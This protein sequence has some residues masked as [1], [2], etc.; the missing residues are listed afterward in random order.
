[1]FAFMV[2]PARARAWQARLRGGETIRLRGEVDAGREPSAYLI[3][4]AIILGRRRDQEVVFSCHLDHPNPG[5]NDN[6]SGCAG[7]LEVA[8]TL[9][10]LIRSGALP[11]PERTI[12]FLWPAEMEGTIS[13]LNAR[14][15]SARR[16]LATIHPHMIAGNTQITK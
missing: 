6:A 1:P 14:P 8:R 4:T 5:A 3:P 9:S 13:L 7:E 16:A 11:Q 2:T 15:E 12:R 10:H